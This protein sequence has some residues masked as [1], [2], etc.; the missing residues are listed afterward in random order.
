MYERP[1]GNF[2]FLIAFAR[3]LEEAIATDRD[4]DV[5][6]SVRSLAVSVGLLLAGSSGAAGE[7]DGG[8]DEG[9][10]DDDAP[11][12]DT[13]LGAALARIKELERSAGPP[14]ALDVTRRRLVGGGSIA[15]EGEQDTPRPV[16]RKRRRPAVLNRAGSGHST[17]LRGV[18][19]KR[20]GK[21]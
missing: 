1:K 18:R 8:D 13:P 10:D 4:D 3:Q 12:D 16:G 17:P 6:E 15:R 19:S 7:D 5:S 2:S 11:G 14:A 9:V 21:K 20:R